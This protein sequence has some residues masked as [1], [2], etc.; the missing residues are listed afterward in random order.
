MPDQLFTIKLGKPL[1]Y[2]NGDE[3]TEFLA[4]IEY[5]DRPAAI[6]KAV[7]DRKFDGD[8]V[9]AQS[10]PKSP[11]AA[12]ASGAVAAPASSTSPS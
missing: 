2:I 11:A 12:G 5:R 4:N 1:T 9:V 7:A 6:A 8:S 10:V 3:T